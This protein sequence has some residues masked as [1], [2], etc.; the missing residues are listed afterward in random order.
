MTFGGECQDQLIVAGAASQIRDMKL[1]VLVS[2]L[3]IIL[4]GQVQYR[5]RPSTFKYDIRI[6]KM[7]PKQNRY[8]QQRST[9]K[10]FFEVYACLLNGFR[11]RHFLLFIKMAPKLKQC[12]SGNAQSEISRNH[13]QRNHKSRADTSPTSRLL[14]WSF[15]L[16]CALPPHQLLSGRVTWPPSCRGN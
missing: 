15:E 2:M 14:C 3:F 13:I 4:Q 16:E 8:F 12:G 10:R 9:L 6:N 1:L 11:G 7:I 5:Y